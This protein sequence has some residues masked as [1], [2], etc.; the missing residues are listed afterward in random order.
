MTVCYGGDM[1]AKLSF[2]DLVD[3]KKKS[4]TK[5]AIIGSSIA[6]SI[7]LV[8]GIIFGVVPA[9]YNPSVDQHYDE[10]VASVKTVNHLNAQMSE[11]LQSPALKKEVEGF[12]KKYPKNQVVSAFSERML[13]AHAMFGRTQRYTPLEME[14]SDAEALTSTVVFFAVADEMS[15]LKDDHFREYSWAMSFSTLKK[16]G[17]LVVKYNPAAM[18]M[19]DKTHQVSRDNEKTLSSWPGVHQHQTFVISK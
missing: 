17:E 16:L 5:W 11:I 10:A 4:T 8:C 9:C 6:V 19:M 2:D 18:E 7:A 15:A 14:M 3:D 12:R 1:S 13:N